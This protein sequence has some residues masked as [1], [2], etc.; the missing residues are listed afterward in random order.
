[1]KRRVTFKVPIHDVDVVIIVTSDIPA[2][3]KREFGVVIDNTRMAC[4]GYQ[5][6]KFG[7]FLEPSA[8]RRQEIIVHEIFHMTHRILE[9]CC[10]NFDSGHHE[11]GAYL[12]E[13][14]TKKIFTILNAT[15]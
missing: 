13:Y 8:K 1:M 10:M 4:L 15:K 6:R 5:G 3:Y 9:K 14:L 11:M 7:L 12:C 2:A